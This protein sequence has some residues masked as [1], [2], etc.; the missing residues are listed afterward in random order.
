MKGIG[1]KEFEQIGNGIRFY[2]GKN[3]LVKCQRVKFTFRVSA[4]RIS[5]YIT[6]HVS[7]ELCGNMGILLFCDVILKITENLLKAL[8]IITFSLSS[9]VSHM[10]KVMSEVLYWS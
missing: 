2:T 3:P 7:D 10:V 6:L 4:E 9:C 8:K 1:E 5:W